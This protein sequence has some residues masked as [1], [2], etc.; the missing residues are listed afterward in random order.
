MKRLDYA[1]AVVTRN[2]PDALRLSIPRILGQSRPPAQL[3]V[4]D[5]S[6]DHALTLDA[7]RD[8]VG[9][10]PVEVTIRH[11]EPGISR[12]R[13]IAIDL[14][15]QP[16]VCMPDD[17]SIWF[18]G[19]A[20]AKLDA[21]ER[22]GKGM[23]VAVCAAESPV[24]PEGFLG[25]EGARYE[26][27][28]E[29]RFRQRIAHA[30]S[31][32]EKRFVP[33]P[34]KLLGRSFWPSVEAPAWFAENDIV[35]VEFMT[36]FRMSFRTEVIRRVRFEERFT[37]YS[38]FED[39]DASLGAWRMGTVIGARRAKVFHYKSPERRDQG[40]RMGAVQIL[41]KACVVAKHSPVGHSARSAMTR[42]ARYKTMQYRMGAGDEFGKDRLAGARAALAE[43]PALL[44]ATPERAIEA[45]ED[46]LRRCLPVENA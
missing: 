46:A 43:L 18:P 36:G 42:F 25:E 34:A 39:I 1:A 29:D 19:V 2:R 37:R 13:N 44:R 21:Y 27:R 7:V 26:M 23:I 5:S 33:E 8:A 9:A 17:D 20:E 32:F 15:T 28:R 3:V 4:V 38:L 12:Q 30:R 24:P 40:R 16:I 22:D 35:L 45:Y 6:D 41:N 14:V 10:H 31:A 11:T